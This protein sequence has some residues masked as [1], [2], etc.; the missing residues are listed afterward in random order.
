MKYALKRAAALLATMAI[1]SFLTF[2]AFDLISD[3]ATVMLGTSATPERLA[4]PRG[5]L[6]SASSPGTWGCPP[7]IISRCGTSWPPR[8]G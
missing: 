1:V 6:P 5:E 3:T 4:A 2:A 7:A 8:W